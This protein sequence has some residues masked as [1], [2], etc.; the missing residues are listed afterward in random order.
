MERQKDL[1]M[2][3]QRDG[4]IV[5]KRGAEMMRPIIRRRKVETENGKRKRDIKRERYI[6]IERRERDL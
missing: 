2:E 1:D 3:K 4:E 6:K 5:R